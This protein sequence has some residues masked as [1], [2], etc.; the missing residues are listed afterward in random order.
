MEITESQTTNFWSNPT[1]QHTVIY[2]IFVL[3][4][5][6]TNKHVANNVSSLF[7]KILT[8]LPGVIFKQASVPSSVITVP[9]IRLNQSDD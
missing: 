5:E 4:T 2:L 1:T 3:L 7:H 6:T 8:L 9:K